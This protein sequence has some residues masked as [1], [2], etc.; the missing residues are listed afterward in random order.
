MHDGDKEFYPY[1]SM[2]AIAFG[3]VRSRN[4][5]NARACPAN[6][7][8]G[9]RRRAARTTFSN[10]STRETRQAAA[11]KTAALHLNL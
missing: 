11:L 6:E 2:R 5:S 4:T 9:E 7:N 3:E 10:P 1:L 8:A